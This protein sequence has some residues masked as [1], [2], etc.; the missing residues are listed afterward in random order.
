VG[1]LIDQIL[2]GKE[3]PTFGTQAAEEAA[4]LER[5]KRGQPVTT[6]RYFI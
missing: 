4:H 1:D 5:L 6:T 3:Q 2:C